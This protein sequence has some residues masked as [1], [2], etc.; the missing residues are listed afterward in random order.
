[1]G[2]CGGEGFQLGGREPHPTGQ[3]RQIR[4]GTLTTGGDDLFGRLLPT[5]RTGAR[6]KRTASAPSSSRSTFAC[7]AEVHTSARS[8]RTPRRRASATS[9][10][11]EQ[12]PIGWAAS[13]PA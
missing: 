12:N 7:T 9:D 10:C 5:P 8:T 4:E 1:Q 13:N 11:G 3:V 2:A 6:P